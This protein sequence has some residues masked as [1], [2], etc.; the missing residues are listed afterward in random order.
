M[1]L[2]AVLFDFNGVIVD[3]EPIHQRLIEQILIHENLK[4][5]LQE[6]QKFCLGR[7]DRACLNDLLSQRGRK[8]TAAYLDKLIA[9]KSQD[10]RLQLEALPQIPLFPGL[11]TLLH[12]LQ[13]AQIKRAI[14]TGALRAEVKAVLTQ[15]QLLADFDLIV[16]AEDIGHSKPDPEGYRLAVQC[17]SLEYPDLQLCPADCLAI[18]DTFVGITAAK[19]AGISVVGVAHTYPFHL[20]QRR[21]NW[22]ID[23]LEDLEI[24][25]IQAILDRSLELKNI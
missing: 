19:Q 14:V 21:A 9:Q 2:K 1:P 6:I 24:P 11:K 25:R 7:S 23:R 18:E 4:P 3:D 15:A 17:L 20:L 5:Q 10:Y 12:H 8:V 16:A 22:A 13:T